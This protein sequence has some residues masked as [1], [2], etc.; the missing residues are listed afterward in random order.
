[1]SWLKKHN[2]NSLYSQ[3]SANRVQCINQDST[4]RH[5]VFTPTAGLQRI[6]YPVPPGFGSAF[7]SFP[8]GWIGNWYVDPLPHFTPIQTLT[9]P[10]SRYSYNAGTPAVPGMVG[11][12]TFDGWNGVTFFDVSAIVNPADKVGVMVI[13]PL[14][15]T[16]PISGCN[17]QG[18]CQNQYNHPNDVAQSLA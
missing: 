8:T 5:I 3:A 4:V 9:N 6:P 14:G 2:R 13:Y 12:V 10:P 17:N 16:T 15:A 1:M 11:E 18:A 7:Q